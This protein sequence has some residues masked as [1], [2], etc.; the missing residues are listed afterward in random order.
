MLRM[1]GS[2]VRQIAATVGM[3]TATVSRDIGEALGE[4][5]DPHSRDACRLRGLYNERYN[6][7]LDTVWPFAISP[8]DD[9]EERPISGHDACAFD[10]AL[11]ILLAICQLH[12]VDAPPQAETA[13]LPRERKII[14]EF[15]DPPS[16]DEQNSWYQGNSVKSFGDQ[17][18]E[19]KP[20]RSLA[21]SQQ[22]GKQPPMVPAGSQTSMHAPRAHEGGTNGAPK[23]PPPIDGPSHVAS[24]PPPVERQATA[25]GD[26]SLEIAQSHAGHF[27][28]VRPAVESQLGGG[29][30]RETAPPPDLAAVHPDASGHLL[31]LLM[32][33]VEIGAIPASAGPPD[34]LD[35]R[36]RSCPSIPADAEKAPAPTR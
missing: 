31:D 23:S 9:Q 21:A 24:P 3:S 33:G 27:R 1:R 22:T 5:V 13:N 20:D 15:V 12:A 18:Y 14:I 19:P 25:G 29:D 10:R 7:L 6:R 34:D 2:T 8:V 17:P 30:D 26:T 32:D 35:D 36:S 28:A 11:S 4:L 16:L